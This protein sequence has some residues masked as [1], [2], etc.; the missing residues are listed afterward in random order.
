MLNTQLHTQCTHSACTLRTNANAHTQPLM[1]SD[2]DS[3]QIGMIRHSGPYTQH[4][5]TDHYMNPSMQ[6]PIASRLVNTRPHN[7]W[8]RFRRGLKNG[9]LR[10]PMI[11]QPKILVYTRITTHEVITKFTPD[12]RIAHA[13]LLDNR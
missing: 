10:V 5:Y 12:I 9:L 8:I 7:Y 4:R 2:S 11:F 1:W 6:I 3:S 13:D